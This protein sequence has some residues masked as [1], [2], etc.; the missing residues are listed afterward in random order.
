MAISIR[1]STKERLKE[2]AAEEKMSMSSYI[3]KLI[4][5]KYNNK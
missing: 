1:P 2:L 3:G 4:D 5:E